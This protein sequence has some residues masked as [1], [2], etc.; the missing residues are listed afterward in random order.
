MAESA[1]ITH[2]DNAVPA[3]L[4]LPFGQLYFGYPVIPLKTAE[5]KESGPAKNFGGSGQSLRAARKGQSRQS[6]G[7]ASPASQP[8]SKDK[9]ESALRVID[10]NQTKPSQAIDRLTV[11]S[12]LFTQD[13]QLDESR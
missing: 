1:A 2:D 5:E 6:S 10:P 11:S 8:D 7:T 4:N 3:P 13:G 12:M 9:G